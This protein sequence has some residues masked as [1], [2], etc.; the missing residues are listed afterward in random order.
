MK[1]GTLIKVIGIGGGGSNAVDR[2][3]QVRSWELAPVRTDQTS[4]ARSLAPS[5]SQILVC[6]VVQIVV[7]IIV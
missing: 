4:R 5:P 1:N 6:L 2:M 3:I 7:E